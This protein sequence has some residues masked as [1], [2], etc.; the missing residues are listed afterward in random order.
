M[1]NRYCPK[2]VGQDGHTCTNDMTMTTRLLSYFHYKYVLGI[3]NKFTYRY[4][5]YSRIEVAPVAVLDEHTTL[6]LTSVSLIAC[7]YF[8]IVSVFEWPKL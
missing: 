5:F 4:I 1:R 8:P 3:Y 7:R 6:S 2:H